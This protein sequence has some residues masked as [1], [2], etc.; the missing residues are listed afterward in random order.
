MPKVRESIPSET[1]YDDVA[2]AIETCGFN[3]DLLLASLMPTQSDGRTRRP[4]ASHDL[5]EQKL[6]QKIRNKVWSLAPSF[7]FLVLFSC[8][9]SYFWFCSLA[10]VP[11][12]ALRIAFERD[13]NSPCHPNF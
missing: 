5:K 6:E 1:C 3:A 10:F 2:H 11:I 7:L 9:R 13:K 8:L 4:Y 12:F